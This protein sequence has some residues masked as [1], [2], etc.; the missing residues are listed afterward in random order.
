[1]AA[2][3]PVS[4]ITHLLTFVVVCKRLSTN[5]MLFHSILW[6]K[7]EN[8]IFSVFLENYLGKSQKWISSFSGMDAVYG[9]KIHNR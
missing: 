6:V 7:L 4:V 9:F 3:V 1:M 5:S 2:F 8:Q